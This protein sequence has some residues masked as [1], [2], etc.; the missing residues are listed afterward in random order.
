MKN[1]KKLRLKTKSK[2]ALMSYEQNLA[3]ALLAYAEIDKK[4]AAYLKSFVAQQVSDSLPKSEK[5]D[6]KKLEAIKLL[7]PKDYATAQKKLNWLIENKKNSALELL[8]A[9][10]HAHTNEIIRPLIIG[11]V[12]MAIIGPT[13]GIVSKKKVMSV[14]V[15]KK[16]A[17]QKKTATLVARVTSDLVSS[18]LLESGG[19]ASK[20]E[21]DLADWLFGD[22]EIMLYES[23]QN[24]LQEVK[25]ELE[26]SK[27][28]FSITKKDNQIVA[29][30]MSPAVN[31]DYLNKQWDKI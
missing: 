13:L 15:D 25:K 18:A 29:L 12:G 26:D 7:L 10:S 2:T 4:F 9:S 23:G 31:A 22:K 19:E 8:S 3:L 20:L 24:D 14:V 30:A 1:L 6:S 5:L 28:L 27:A 21:P 11:I 16:I 17:G